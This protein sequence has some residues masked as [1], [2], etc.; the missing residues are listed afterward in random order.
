[1][2]GD[3]KTDAIQMGTSLSGDF[4]NLHVERLSNFSREWGMVLTFAIDI[5]L[6]R[7]EEVCFYTTEALV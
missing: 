7:P 2:T 1:M 6:A 5:F 3:Y 4:N